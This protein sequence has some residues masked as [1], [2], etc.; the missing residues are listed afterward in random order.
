MRI[1]AAGDNCMDVYEG[2]NQMFPGGNPINVAVYFKRLGGQ[3]SYIGAVGNDTYGQFMTDAISAKGVD[4]SHVRVLPGNTAI[5]KVELKNG[6]RI[7]GDYDEGVLADFKLTEDDIDFICSH[8]L[9]VT[10]L[11]GMLENDLHQFKSRSLPV[12]FDFATKLDHPIV[13]KAIDYVD[14]AFFAYDEGDNTFIR[15]YMEQMYARSPKIITVTLGDKGSIAY[16]GNKYTSFGIVPCEVK[17]T[18]G[19]GDSYIAGFL[20]GILRGEPLAECMRMGAE[21]A[22]VTLAYLGA[23]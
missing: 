22:S 17:D 10:G 9:L 19:A 20:Y 5:T 8:D 21:N 13:E 1:A 18:M 7:F 6:E 16:D 12:A 11:W 2:L 14:Y 15:D 23:W 4:I 3:A